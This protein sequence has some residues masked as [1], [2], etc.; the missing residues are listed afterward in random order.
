MT[1]LVPGNE[2]ETVAFATDHLIQTAKATLQ[3]QPFF[4]L[5][6]SGGSTPKKIYSALAERKNDLDYTRVLLFWGDERGV[7]PRDPESNY[8]MAM[9]A[10]LSSLP[11]LPEHVF[12]MKVEEQ[13]EDNAQLYE[14]TLLAKTNGR[15]DFIMLGL[16]DDGHTASLF[17]HSPLLEEK[18]KLVAAAYISEKKQWRMTLTFPCINKATLA[19]FYVLGQGKAAILEKVLKGKPHAYP[20]QC[21]RNPNTLWVSDSSAATLL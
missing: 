19:V 18:K 20:A 7:P 21:V 4:S 6:L 10:G 12:R 17:P 13:P 9:T 8:H 16:G 2:S 3:K 14:K 1:L 5:A 11:F 15:L